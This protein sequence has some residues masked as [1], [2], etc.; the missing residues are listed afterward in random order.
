MNLGLSEINLGLARVNLGLYKH[1][2]SGTAFVNDQ[3]KLLYAHI[4]GI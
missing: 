2:L 1:P 4:G 3:H